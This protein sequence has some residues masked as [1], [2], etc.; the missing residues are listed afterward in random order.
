M[1]QHCPASQ[2][3]LRVGL[4]ERKLEFHAPNG[5]VQLV[6][7]VLSTGHGRAVIK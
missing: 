6:E 3:V 7:L 4:R 1:K 2:L 5:A